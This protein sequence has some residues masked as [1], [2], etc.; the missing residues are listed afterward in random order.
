[1]RKSVR[2]NGIYH[3]YNISN[4]IPFEELR[5][6]HCNAWYEILFVM[7]GTGRFIIDGR[8]YPIMLVMFGSTRFLCEFLRDLRL[9]R[10]GAFAFS[11]EEGTPAAEMEF[12]DNEIAVKRAETIEMIQSS[13]MDDWCDSMIGKTLEVLVDGFD[14]EAEQFY[15]R[16]YAD[17]PDIDGRVWIATDEPIREGQFVTVTIDG[18]IEGDLS[19]Y[20]PEE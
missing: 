2:S 6:N 1:M 5:K 14:E 12:V 7:K 18:C 8:E 4:E 15:G 11:P 13:I 17:S 16:S 19:G 9:E 20:I 3:V 10:V